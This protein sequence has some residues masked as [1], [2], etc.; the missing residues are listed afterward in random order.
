MM[1]S[2]TMKGEPWLASP[3]PPSGRQQRSW[4]SKIMAAAKVTVALTSLA[5]VSLVFTGHIWDYTGSNIP[6]HTSSAPL[7]PHDSANEWPDIPS[8][9]T[10]T[11][12]SCYAKQ[13]DCARLDLPM[14][15]QDPTADDDKRVVLAIMRLRAN[16]NSTVGPYLGPVFF[17]PGGPGGSGTWSL[18]DHGKLLQTVI[19]DNHDL[20]TFDPRGVGASVPRIECW[21]TVQSRRFW[22]L[23][24]VGVID[25]HPGVLYDAYARAEAFSQVCAR[26]LNSSGLLR[27]SST[28]YHARDMLEILTQM[29]ESELKY[30]GFSY[31]TVLGGIFATLWPDKVARMVSDGNVDYEEWFDDSRINHLRDTDKVMDA[32]YTTCHAAGP[33]KCAFHAATPADIELRLSTLL[34]NLT[35]N[36]VIVPSSSS[37]PDLPELITYSKVK[38]L[39]S[40]TL[41]QPVRMF[42]TFATVLAALEARDGQPFYNLTLS[43][44]PP[45]SSLCNLDTVPPTVPVSGP[46]HEDTPD[47]FPAIYCSDAPPFL[48]S[49]TEF[50]RYAARLQDISRAAGAVLSLTRLSCAG[51][52]GVRPGWAIDKPVG[53]GNGTAH[54]ILFVANRADNVTPLVSARNNSAAFPGSEVLVV[55]GWGHTSLA[56]P[57]RCVAGV[58]RGYFQTGGMPG[59]VIGKEKRCAVDVGPFDGGAEVAGMMEGKERDELADAVRRLGLERRLGFMMGPRLGV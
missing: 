35:V 3:A 12:H 43:G 7:T 56:T 20:V 31:G 16:P 19:G 47:A 17:N 25:S 38:R 2:E 29:G 11:W 15:W 28:V 22:E 18:R 59:S 37:G 33:E 45:P 30:W 9:R 57:S 42:S 24:E 4:K 44:S 58:V 41:Y 39:I 48:S 32:F 55:E 51:R 49:P 13:Y 6:H 36:P 5:L 40:T 26:E 10:L 52:A 34:S 23:Q 21:D 50:A 27:H 1:G 8:S 54:P 53:A 46:G 14:D